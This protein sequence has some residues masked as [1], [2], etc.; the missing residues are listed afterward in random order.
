MK[1]LGLLLAASWWVAAQPAAPPNPQPKPPDSLR[2]LSNRLEGLS[3]RVSRSLVQIFSSGY[4]LGGEGETGTNAAVVTRQRATGSGV[5]LSADGYIVTNA[6]VVSNAHR[7]RVRLAVEMPG[8]TMQPS[9]KMLDARIVGVDRDSDLAVLKIDRTGLPFLKLG[10]SDTLR[11]GELIMAFGNPLGLENSVS[12]GVVSSVARQI[13]PDD[14]MIYIQTDAP[15]NPGNSGG[16]LVD[17]D[18]RVMGINTF[19]LSQSG[20]SEGLGFA[21]P[22][23]IVKNVFVQIKAEG[24]VHRSEIGVFAQT[25]TPPLAAG[26]R[27]AQ[28]WGVVLSDVTPGGSGDKAGL[29]VGDIVISLNGKIMTNV[30]QL[31]T[32]LYRYSVGQKVSVEVLREGSRITYPVAVTQREDDPQ[33][34]AD[35]VDPAKNVVLKLGILG[36]AIDARIAEMLPD[37]RNS[38]GV[39]VAARGGDSP[40]TGDSLQLGDVIYS[41]N[42]EPVSS[43]EALR[44][45]VDALKDTEPLVLQ[46]ERNGRLQY[47][48][49]TIE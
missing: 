45:F 41:V 29:K 27:L 37:L 22:S 36:I 5:I 30:R 2:D 43:V 32:N 49:M 39:V 14:T 38:Y 24:H 10:D 11:Q 48:T 28:D 19:I 1:L 17:A 13:K 3:R 16:P 26:M 23:N 7:V 12:M 6:H 18:S 35:M 4:V 15:I 34:F 21:I 31:E 42:T 47:I 25:I 33:R 46:V 8:R 40:Y 9:G 44:A 20:G